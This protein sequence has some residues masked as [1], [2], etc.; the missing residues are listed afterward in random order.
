[1]ALYSAP[2]PPT[3]HDTSIHILCLHEGYL[4]S[5]KKKSACIYNNFVL[6]SIIHLIIL[7]EDQTMK[8]YKE[9]SAG[10]GS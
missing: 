1:M 10:A 5:S 7:L 3:F 6:L 4:S 2:L 9:K 8:D